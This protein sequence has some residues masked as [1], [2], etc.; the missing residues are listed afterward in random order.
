[1]DYVDQNGAI[2]EYGWNS[3][4]EEDYVGCAAAR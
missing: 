3:I 2:H 4:Y 1:M